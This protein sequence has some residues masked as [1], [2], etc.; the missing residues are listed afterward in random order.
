M[1]GFEERRDGLCELED[2][3]QVERED[4][5]PCRGRVGVVGLAPVAAAVVDEDVELC[6]VA[7]RYCSLC[8]ELVLTYFQPSSSVHL[9]S[10]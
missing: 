1:R 3:L 10:V 2:A 4:A 8:K 7:V 5:V 9:Q 6:N